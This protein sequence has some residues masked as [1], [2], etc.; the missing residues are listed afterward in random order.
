MIKHTKPFLGIDYDLLAITSLVINGKT[1]EVKLHHK[2]IYSYLLSLSGTYQK[3][4]PSLKG[5][6]ERLGVGTDQTVRR[7]IKDL[8]SFGWLKIE[9]RAGSTNDY[10]VLPYEQEAQTQQ[11]ATVKAV[12]EQLPPTED[13][14]EFSFDVLDDWDAPL[15]WEMEETPSDEKV[16]NDNEED[17]LENFA[18]L[19]IQEKHTRTGGA[20]F[21]EFATSLAC[22]HRIKL[23]NGIEA[24]F[25]KKHPKVYEDFDIP[26]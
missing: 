4:T 19:I 13:N 12:Q 14:K 3:V 24:Y 7:H 1:K 9:E 20:S 17:V 16:A 22:Q 10:I 5:I 25:A 2:I 18:S 23:P 26:F 6:G 21:I 11:E 15:P 8:V